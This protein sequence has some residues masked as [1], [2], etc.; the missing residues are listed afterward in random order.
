LGFRPFVYH[1]AKRYQQN[2][3]VAN[4]CHG[5]SIAIEG[6]VFHQQQFLFDLQNQLPPFA[7]IDSLTIQQKPLE[8]FDT[9]QIKSSITDDGIHSAFVLPDIGPCQACISDICNPQSRFYRYPFTSC[10]YC[11][12]RYSIMLQQPYDRIRTSMAGFAPCSECLSEYS[13]AEN[14]RFHSQTIACPDCGPQLSLLDSDGNSLYQ[15]EQALSKAI[16]FLKQGKII[17]IKGVGGFQLLADATNSQVVGELRFRKQR[18]E[19]PFALMV[20]N[21][22]SAKELCQINKT[23]QQTLTSQASPIVLLKR[24]N[25][26][27]VMDMVAPH[28]TLL[29]LMLPA[30]PLHQL[31]AHDFDNPLITTSGNRMNETICITDQQALDRLGDIADFFLTHDRAIIRPL[32]DSIVRSINKKPVVLRRARGYTPS[33]V[34]I[35]KPLPDTLALGGQMKNAVAISQGKQLILSQHIGDLNSANSRQQFQQT[36]TDLQS[37]YSTT[38]STVIHDLHPDYHSSIVASQQE[39]KQVAVQH[40]HAHILAC[41][42]E[43]DLQA[44]VLGFAWDGS[45]LGIDNTSWGGECLLLI[46]KGFQRFAYSRSFPLVGGD[47]AAS[48]PRRSALGLLY[49]MNFDQLSDNKNLDFLSAFTQQELNLL[50]Q[51]LKKQLNCPYTSSIGRLFDA[52][53]SLL[54]LC[55]INQF[56][57]Q[58]AMQLEQLASTIHTNE[59]Y[60]FKLIEGE[61]I[62]IDWYS[63]I[64]ALLADLNRQNKNLVAAKFHNTLAEIMLRIAKLGQQKNIVLSGGCFQNAY[65]TERCVEKLKTAGFSVYTHEKIPPNDG[66]LALGQLYAQHKG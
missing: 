43:H 42:A 28:N 39:I 3:W 36:L 16:H 12:P 24:L 11:G 50:Q 41:M 48:E 44:P 31:L 15:C 22:A 61:C 65:L 38:P 2:G 46:E 25:S 18:P 21:L 54:G 5:V 9:F 14:R 7:I 19:K 53:S 8:N 17:A 23:E 30:L 10:C 4:S 60:P 37:F 33:P 62:I 47:K 35:S 27:H 66:G 51:S 13:S 40:H 34:T 59:S 49:E 26:K 56:E 45:G 32:D 1:L 57:G 64:T 63:T 55:H 6:S 29:G 20:E 58:A 52:V